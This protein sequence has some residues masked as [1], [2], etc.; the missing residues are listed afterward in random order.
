MNQIRKTISNSHLCFPRN[1]ESKLYIIARIFGNVIQNPQK[2]KDK[3]ETPLHHTN[4]SL[5]KPLF[6]TISF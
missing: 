2:L 4:K 5:K 6:A 1:Y 3:M